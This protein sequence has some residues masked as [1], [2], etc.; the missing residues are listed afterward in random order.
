[1]TQWLHRFWLEDD[2]QDL[3]EY[4]LLLTFIAITTMWMMGSTRPVVSQIWHSANAALGK[5]NSAAQPN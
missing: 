3:I 4:S 1:M 5:A 2:G